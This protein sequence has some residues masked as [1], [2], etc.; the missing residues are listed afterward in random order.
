MLRAGI[1]FFSYMLTVCL[2]LS[3]RAALVGLRFVYAL[4]RT[5][6]AVFLRYMS[7][8]LLPFHAL[9]AVFVLL[10]FCGFVSFSESNAVLRVD[11]SQLQEICPRL[12]GSAGSWFERKELLAAVRNSSFRFNV[13]PELVLAVIAAESRCASDA[14]SRAGAQGLMQLMPKTAEWLGVE[15][16]HSVRENI[17]GGSKYLSSLIERFNGDL[18]LALAAYNAG[19][20]RVARYKRVPPF[21]ETKSYI[22]RVINFYKLLKGEHLETRSI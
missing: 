3:F 20:T 8:F 14:R 22:K 10:V 5:L 13:E 16:P 11:S 4:L 2:K 9:L 21:P 18:E 19:P 6:A 15:N 7:R 1:N 17:D 12:L